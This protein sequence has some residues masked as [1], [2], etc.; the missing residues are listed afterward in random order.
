MIIYKTIN[1]V[2]GKIY[3]GQDTKDNK[4]YLGSGK[5]LRVAIKKYGKDNFKKEIIETCK[6]QEELNI[7]EIFWINYYNSTNRKIGYNIAYGG[8]GKLGC[9]H[10]NTTKLHFSKQ[11]LGVHNSNFGKKLP[12]YQR[13]ALS[14]AGKKRVGELNTFF[15]KKHTNITKQ[16]IGL[17]NSIILTKEKE[18]EI[19]KL[20]STFSIDAIAEQLNIGYKKV[21]N[22]LKKYKVSMRKAGSWLIGKKFPNRILTMET[23]KK[24][25]IA[26]SGEKHPMFGIR[27][28]NHP[29]YKQIGKERQEEI[30]LM[31][32]TGKRVKEIYKK[33]GIS[34]AKL[35]DILTKNKIKRK[36][37]GNYVRK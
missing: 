36:G 21:Y 29:L 1:L 24:I 11:R 27:G 19:V 34:S 14:I 6:T 20:Y 4:Y 18:E 32:T 25:S 16:K 26:F 8:F 9:K 22:V 10:T 2:N 23:R 37:R 7:R 3:I 13:K 33:F 12:D 17:A 35:I 15:G 30:I 5:I 28:E 31:Y